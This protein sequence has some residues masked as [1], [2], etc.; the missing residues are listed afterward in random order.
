MRAGR[1]DRRSGILV[2]YTATSRRRAGS[3]RARG[4]AHKIVFFEGKSGRGNAKIN[5]YAFDDEEGRLDLFTT[6]YND[7]DKPVTV[8]RTEIRQAVEQALRFFTGSLSGLG[9][10]LEASSRAAEIANQ[11]AAMREAIKDIRIHVLMDGVSTAKKLEPEEVQGRKVRVEIWDIERLFRG[12]QAGT[13]RDEIEIDFVN[14]YGGGIPCLAAPPEPDY[15]GYLA[16]IPA[17]LLY[18]LYDDYGAQ[19]LELNVR[20]FLSARGKINAGIRKTLRENPGRFLAYNNGIVITA[21]HLAL[22]SQDARHPV[23]TAARGL[24]IVN[25]GQTTASIHRARKVDGADIST[26]FVSAKITVVDP[27]KHELFVKEVSRYAN[28]QNVIQIA[29]FSANDPFHVELERLSQRIWCPGEQGRWFYERARGQYQVEKAKASA[30]ASR[31]R[32]FESQTP[33]FRRFIKT[34]VSK[35]E[36]SWAQKPHFVSLGAQKNFDMFMQYLRTDRR[37]WLPDD[38]YYRQ[39]VSKAILYRAIEKVVRKEKFPA[40]RANIVTYLMSYLVHRSGTQL[41]LDAIWRNQDITDPLRDLVR[42]WS[43][44]ISSEI[45][46]GAAGRNVTEWC[47]KEKCWEHISSLQLDMPD[48]LP[49]E[50]SGRVSTALGWSPKSK[51]MTSEDLENIAL[52]KTIDASSWMKIFAWGRKTGALHY[53][54]TGIAQ[55]LSGYAA[56]GW[57][58]GLSPKQAK[59]GAKMV[60]LAKEQGII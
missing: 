55:T 17:E 41:D 5:G 10:E 54:M 23:I 15:Q 34:D 35:Y 20:S 49:E 32:A 6:I 40:Y 31:K 60:R 14:Q 9:K 28:T 48:D 22:E 59:Q 46:S 26:V 53:K 3:R 52:C 33:P 56:E 36:H 51:S 1:H 2:I 24:Q 42:T 27:A 16:I 57:P 13:P 25:G 29:D 18:R 30:S 45:I 39:L 8:G 44:N 47:K 50:L 19:L 4:R 38:L 7:T 12:M 11:I 58:R 21:D 37:D 43:H